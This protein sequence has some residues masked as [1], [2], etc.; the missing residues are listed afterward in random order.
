MAASLSLADTHSACFQHNPAVKPD[1]ITLGKALS[2]GLY[3]VS[4]VLS[5]RAIMSVIKPGERASD[6]PWPP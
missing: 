2:G 5:S 3:P 1:I 4:A 6:R